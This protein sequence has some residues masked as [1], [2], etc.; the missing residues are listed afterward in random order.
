METESG[1]EGGFLLFFLKEDNNTPFFLF[2]PPLPPLP[3]S[4]VPP[5][6]LSPE[7]FS[8]LLSLSFPLSFCSPPPHFFLLLPSLFTFFFLRSSRFSSPILS[9]PLLSLAS[10]LASPHIIHLFPPLFSFS[11]PIL[12]SLFSPSL[13]SSLPL[14]SPL[15]SSFLFPL[16]S[17]CHPVKYET[18]GREVL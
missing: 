14:F 8:P 12:F 13:F 5:P 7:F 2:A 16:L 1:T 10:I 6:A 3:S 11:L 15:S 4:P 17:L 18:K 9:S